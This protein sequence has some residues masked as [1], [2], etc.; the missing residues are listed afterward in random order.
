M[1]AS[2]TD[3]VRTP[4]MRILA[5]LWGLAGHIGRTWCHPSQGKLCELVAKRYRRGISRRHLNRHL[6]ALERDGYIRRIRRHRR[7]PGGRIDMHSTAYAIRLRTHRLFSQLAPALGRFKAHL[8]RR[9]ASSAVTDPAQ[10][11]TPIS[12][13]LAGGVAKGAPPPG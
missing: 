9:F 6:G 3:Y 7:G 2:G 5:V 11:G 13:I 8:E 1:T 12:T 10:C 4:D